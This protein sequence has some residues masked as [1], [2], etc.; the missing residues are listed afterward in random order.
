MILAY[1]QIYDTYHTAFRVAS[2]LSLADGGTLPRDQLRLVD[3]LSVFPAVATRIRLPASHRWLRTEYRKYENKYFDPPDPR[4]VF[5]QVEHV[6]HAAYNTLAGTNEDSGAEGLAVSE[7]DS[8]RITALAAGI[9]EVLAGDNESIRV[10]IK[11][12]K[13]LLEIPFAGENGLKNRSKLMRW[14]HDS[15]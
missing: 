4:L 6:F 2:I 8:G 15:A 11:V 14:Q 5:W 13:A 12:A 1:H 10:Y 3:F 9:D 7:F